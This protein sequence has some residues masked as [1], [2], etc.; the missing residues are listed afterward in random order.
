MKTQA[1]RLAFLVALMFFLLVWLPSSVSGS[2]TRAKKS[3]TP[4]SGFPG[5]MCGWGELYATPQLTWPNYLATIM[6]SLRVLRPPSAYPAISD[7]RLGYF[8][9][10]GEEATAEHTTGASPT[11]TVT[12]YPDGGGF[13]PDCPN[14]L[15]GYAYLVGPSRGVAMGYQATAIANFFRT[16]TQLYQSPGGLR[17]TL[18]NCEDSLDQLEFE[19]SKE[20]IF[21]GYDVDPAINGA[22]SLVV[23]FPTKHFHFL[24]R[25]TYT[26]SPTLAWSEPFTSATMN[27]PGELIRVRIYDRNENTVI[28]TST[29]WSPAAQ[30]TTALPYEVNVISLYAGTVPALYPTNLLIRDNVGFSSGTFLNGWI[31]LCF[32][33][34][35]RLIRA[36]GPRVA[37]PITRFAHAGTSFEAYVGLPTIAV[38]LQSFENTALTGGLY[39]EIL[40]AT[41]EV[42]WRVNTVVDGFGFTAVYPD[43]NVDPLTSLEDWLP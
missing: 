5:R 11:W 33:Q 1:P 41:Y 38:A 14:T 36:T 42:E 26:L 35:N 18:A 25:P 20:D 3:L 37:D 19:L 17:P 7:N 27:T 29:W 24:A 6:L 8:E 9:V 4:T 31:W 2:G 12:R 16:R 15:W 28:P 43:Y 13:Y 30:P 10:I 39:G 23:T 32:Q 22:F 34:H 21:A 40:P